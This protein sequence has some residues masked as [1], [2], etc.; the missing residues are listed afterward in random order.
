MI[1]SH[2]HLRDR[3]PIPFPLDFT[4]PVRLGDLP[5]TISKVKFTAGTPGHLSFVFLVNMNPHS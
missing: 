2:Q 4:T 3:K 1:I 5:K